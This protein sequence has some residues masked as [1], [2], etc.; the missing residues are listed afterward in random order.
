[1]NVKVS[2]GKLVASGLHPKDV[3]WLEG[4][5]ETLESLLRALLECEADAYDSVDERLWLRV[6]AVLSEGAA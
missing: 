4:R 6:R 3:L 1:M 2:D 5:V